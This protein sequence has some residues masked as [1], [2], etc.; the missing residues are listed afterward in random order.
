M[1]RLSTQT[2]RFFTEVTSSSRS[3]SSLKLFLLD[4][5]EEGDDDDVEAMHML[6]GRIVH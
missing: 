1:E 3:C 5:D 2:L 6:S 4:G